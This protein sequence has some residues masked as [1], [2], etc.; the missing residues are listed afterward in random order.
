MIYIRTSL[1]LL[2][3]PE[4]SNQK[5]L[6]KQKKQ[7]LPTDLYMFTHY[8][9]YFARSSCTLELVIDCNNS[10]VQCCIFLKFYCLF[11]C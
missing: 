10:I 6:K 9:K 11:S 8:V 4:L 1:A 5:Y 7:N 3:I 2:C